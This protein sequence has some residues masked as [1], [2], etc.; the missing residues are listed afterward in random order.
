MR[1]IQ[2]DTGEKP[3]P[4]PPEFPRPPDYITEAGKPP[5]ERR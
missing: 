4:P 2:K 5:P 3:A 1:N